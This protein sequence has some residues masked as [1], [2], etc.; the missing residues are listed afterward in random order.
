MNIFIPPKFGA[1]KKFENHWIKSTQ[2]SCQIKKLNIINSGGDLRIA[3]I[4]SEYIRNVSL[5][6]QLLL[7]GVQ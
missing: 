1:T 5:L 7:A 2:T 3:F 4:I 6:S